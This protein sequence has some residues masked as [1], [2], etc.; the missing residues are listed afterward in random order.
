LPPEERLPR[1]FLTLAYRGLRDDQVSTRRIAEMLG[2]SDI[3][4]EERL[5]PES[6]DIE[7]GVEP[8]EVYAF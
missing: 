1:A 8:D 4:L 6:A 5:N 7:P 3:E 2:I